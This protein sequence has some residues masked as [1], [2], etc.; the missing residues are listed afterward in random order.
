[1]QITH[2]HKAQLRVLRVGLDKHWK[3]YSEA[4]PRYRVRVHA[5]LHRCKPTG[6]MMQPS[7]SDIHQQE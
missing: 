7:I 2:Q 3:A 1:M 6:Q 4:R 5:G